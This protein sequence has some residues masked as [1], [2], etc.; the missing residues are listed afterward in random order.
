M[1]N[2]TTKWGLGCTDLNGLNSGQ[3]DNQIHRK[4]SG[5]IGVGIG[6]VST[7]HDKFPRVLGGFGVLYYRHIGMI[8]GL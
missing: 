1:D 7:G 5:V 4:E 3:L 8:S 2:W 6:I